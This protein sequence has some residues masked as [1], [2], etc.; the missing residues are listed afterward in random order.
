MIAET[1]D[2]LTRTQ[3]V[4]ITDVFRARVVDVATDSLMIEVTGTDDKIDGLLEILRPFGLIEVARTGQLAMTP[5]GPRLGARVWTHLSWLA[6]ALFVVLA[7][8]AWMSRAGYLTEPSGIIQGARYA[9]VHA[10][11]PAAFLLMLAALAGIALSV[12]AAIGGRTRL[13]ATGMDL[14]AV[15]TLAPNGTAWQNAA[16]LPQARSGLAAVGGRDGRIYAMGGRVAGAPT[17][18]VDIYLPA[19]NRWISGPALPQALGGSN[20]ALAVAALAAFGGRVFL[21][22]IRIGCPRHL[23]IELTA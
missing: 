5:F 7:L 19:I 21:G 17:A 16:A 9:D 14:N 4:Q 2:N 23:K 22:M 15:E 18:R 10:H 12:M 8:A 11:M 3:I 1:L 6:A 13:G 20:G